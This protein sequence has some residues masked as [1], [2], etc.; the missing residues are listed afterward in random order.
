MRNNVEVTESFKGPVAP[1]C[2]ITITAN[3]FDFQN[4][5]APFSS[6]THPSNFFRAVL[7][8]FLLLP[9]PVIVIAVVPHFESTMVFINRKPKHA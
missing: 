9:I 8:I 3:A 7:C 6:H 4:V 2:A 5:L 1:T